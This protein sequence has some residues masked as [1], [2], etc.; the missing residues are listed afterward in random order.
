MDPSQGSSPGAAAAAGLATTSCPP[1]GEALRESLAT[2]GR[3]IGADR[4]YV[5]EN[6]RDPDGRLW[7]NLVGEW[8]RA[9][10]RGL[11]DQP[12]TK[13]H[14][15]SPDFTRW[16]EVLGERDVLTGSVATLPEAERR[17]LAAEGTHSVIAIPIFLADGWWGFLAADDCA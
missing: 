12:G 16:I 4:V 5:F 8:L 3:E 2:V 6:I 10:V 7:M 13:L 14:P 11:F 9:G 1:G 15:Y 17:V